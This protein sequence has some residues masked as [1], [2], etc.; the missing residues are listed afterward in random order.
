M[1]SQQ[2]VNE[3]NGPHYFREPTVYGR[4]LV[5]DRKIWNGPGRE[6]SHG[7]VCTTFVQVVLNSFQTGNVELGRRRGPPAV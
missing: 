2:D 4:A 1:A 3:K 5:L 7:K 6:G